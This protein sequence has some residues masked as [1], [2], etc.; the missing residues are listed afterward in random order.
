MPMAET[1]DRATPMPVRAKSGRRAV[2]AGTSRQP[3]DCAA[4]SVR[5]LALF[6]AFP[7][8]VLGRLRVLRRD[9]RLVAAGMPIVAPDQVLTELFTVYRGWAFSYRITADGRRH[10]V[11]F[12]LPGDLIGTELLGA[13]PTGVGVSALSVVALC[14][15]DAAQLMHAA[16]RAP[17]LGAALAWMSSR[18]EALLAERLAA[19]GRRSAADRLAHL[20][21]ELWTRQRWRE[22]AEGTDCWFPLS[23]QHIADALGLSAEHV[24]RSLSAL[25]RHQLV[26]LSRNRL[27]LP[28]PER[29]AEMCGWSA[30]Y[31]HPRP[32]L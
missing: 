9:T 20:L 26:S 8:D 29:L 1:Q 23:N 2:R 27:Y 32:L 25:R 5:Q 4:C 12:H 18:E 31:L 3:S 24:S 14:V 7:P 11:D 17:A 28:S 13:L 10:I 21:L 16:T 6:Q 19:I 22:P 30:G 15:F